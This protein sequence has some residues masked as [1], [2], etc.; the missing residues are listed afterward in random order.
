MRIFKN[1]LAPLEFVQIYG[2]RNSGTNHLKRLLES[3]IEGENKVLGSWATQSNPFNGAKIFGYKHYYPRAE[4]L[5]GQEG[6][7]KRT[8]FAVMYK[9]PY[10]WLRS[11]LGKPYHFKAS[12][13]GKSLVDLPSIKLAG[14][15]V[16]GEPIP[17]VHPETG[18][19]IN[20]FELRKHKIQEWE[21]LPSL[22]ENVVY[23]NYEELLVDP[24]SVL[25]GIVNAFPS[26]F[27]SKEIEPIE[28][29]PKYIEKY[30]PPAPFSDDEVAVMNGAI[31]WET[32]AKAGYEKNNFTMMGLEPPVKKDLAET[33]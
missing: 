14:V 7:R 23:I 24:T 29:S 26:L 33:A 21:K 2:E 19:N 25:N 6:L 13:E 8:L 20:I 30:F 5:S 15:N 16:R 12:L 28:P 10:T 4:R 1:G 27:I 18:E 32:E 3:N 31:D 11:M 17:D 9:N 22:V